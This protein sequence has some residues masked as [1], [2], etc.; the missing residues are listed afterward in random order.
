M[1]LLAKRSSASQQKRSQTHEGAS[2][3]SISHRGD[4]RL[5]PLA[6]GH[7]KSPQSEMLLHAGD[8]VLFVL[9]PL[10]VQDVGKAH[11]FGQ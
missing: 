9:Q 8:Q 10:D 4:R 3:W 7:S 5:E 11:Q 6:R 1:S 2:L